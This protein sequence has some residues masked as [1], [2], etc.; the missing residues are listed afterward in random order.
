MEQSPFLLVRQLEVRINSALS[1]FDRYILEAP[2]QKILVSIRRE[3]VDAR[4]DIRDYELSET[5]E[6]QLKS[7]TIA[8]KR[9]ETLRKHILAASEFGTFSAADVAD[10]TSQLEAIETRLD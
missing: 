2:Q 5:R 1:A 3:L 10:L 9:L 8:K 4:L 7:A 6:L